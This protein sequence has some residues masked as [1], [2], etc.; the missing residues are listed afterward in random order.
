MPFSLSTYFE[1]ARNLI[2]SYSDRLKGTGQVLL[3]F[4]PPSQAAIL[5]PT[6]FSPP[7]TSSFFPPASP[8]GPLSRFIDYSDPRS[9]RSSFP[10]P[11]PP[12]PFPKPVLPSLCSIDFCLFPLRSLCL[13]LVMQPA[14]HVLRI[15]SHHHPFRLPIFSPS[16]SRAF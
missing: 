5:A 4:P 12:F 14:A 16:F 11:P 15:C 2:Q 3:V 6:N 10:W 13:R 9:T 8:T 7:P 1:T